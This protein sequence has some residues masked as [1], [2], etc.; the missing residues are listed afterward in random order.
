YNA[1]GGASPYYG[2]V[3]VDPADIIG[4]L[5]PN[6]SCGLQAIGRAS[7]FSYNRPIITNTSPVG[8][9]HDYIFGVYVHFAHIVDHHG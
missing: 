6:C 4:Y 3:P 9:S 7:A 2:E 8:G 5:P 1:W